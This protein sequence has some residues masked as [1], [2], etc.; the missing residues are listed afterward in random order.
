MIIANR[1]F[2][3]FVNKQEKETKSEFSC[4]ELR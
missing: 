2:E 4:T 1:F 3:H